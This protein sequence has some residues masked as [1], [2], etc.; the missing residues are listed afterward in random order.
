[1]QV[2][3]D[4]KKHVSSLVTTLCCADMYGTIGKSSKQVEGVRY[5]DNAFDDVH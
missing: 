4:I 5:S 3:D 1:M 2:W